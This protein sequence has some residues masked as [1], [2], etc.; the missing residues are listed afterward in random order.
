MN[1]HWK[2]QHEPHASAWKAIETRARDATLVH[3]IE[4]LAILQRPGSNYGPA[5]ASSLLADMVKHGVVRPLKLDLAGA[6]ASVRAFR[7]IGPS[8]GGQPSTTWSRAEAHLWTYELGRAN[9]TIME[10]AR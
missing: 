5:D 1:T 6:G 9:D 7:G 4:A 10:I 3:G 2:Q 8:A